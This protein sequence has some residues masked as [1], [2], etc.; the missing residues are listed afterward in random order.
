MARYILKLAGK[1]EY[2]QAVD[3]TR[4]LKTT[5]DPNRAKVYS[6]NMLNER[7][8]LISREVRAQYGC[9]VEVIRII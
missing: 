8:F 6:D 7:R 5:E 3:K 4:Y 9:Y 1:N 2:L